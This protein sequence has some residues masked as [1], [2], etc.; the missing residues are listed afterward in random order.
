[1]KDD[2]HIAGSEPLDAQ[3]ETPLN[4]F[5]LDAA[6]ESGLDGNWNVV[7]KERKV[8]RGI[9]N[10][11]GNRRGGPMSF[12]PLGPSVRPTAGPVT[13]SSVASFISSPSG[14]NGH[15]SAA[16]GASSSS[17]SPNLGIG[18]QGRSNKNAPSPIN[19][20]GE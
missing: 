8:G 11:T 14:P 18:E 2:E 19:T 16:L 12:V 20:Q 9:N 4:A 5:S 6:T 17:N 3:Q 15:A 13:R 10:N 7:K 1:M